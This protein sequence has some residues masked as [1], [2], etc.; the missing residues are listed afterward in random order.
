MIS[1]LSTLDGNNN[2]DREDMWIPTGTGTDE[3]EI[4]KTNCFFKPFK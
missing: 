1:T 3:V 2:D 4:C